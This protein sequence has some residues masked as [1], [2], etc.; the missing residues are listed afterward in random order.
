MNNRGEM[1]IAINKRMIERAFFLLIII[2]LVTLY[3]LKGSAGRT[4]DLSANVTLLNQQLSTKDNQ[5]LL[6]LK[7]LTE[8][9]QQLATEKPAAIIVNT[10][11][12]T[13]PVKTLS[14]KITFGWLVNH[15]VLTPLDYNNDTIA[16][17]QTDLTKFE[18]QYHD[19]NDS[20]ERSDLREKIAVLKD[21][22][23]TLKN[24]DNRLKLNKVTITV[25]NGK[26]SNA[27]ID[28]TVCWVAFDCTKVASTG[29]I[30]VDAGED[31][32]ETILLEIPTIMSLKTTQALQISLKQDGK[33]VFKESKTLS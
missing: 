15:S 4:E 14:G 33:E 21:D 30:N 26:D 20:A 1:E 28:Y 3:F 29:F 10:T 7:N 23:E 32:N 12:N 25:Q 19:S 18:A 8:T 13:T 24:D 16:A 2:G 22:L 31:K 6:L 9:Q 27:A 17:K 11:L 5:I